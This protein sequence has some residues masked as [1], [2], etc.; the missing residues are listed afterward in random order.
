MRYFIVFALYNQTDSPVVHQEYIAINGF[1]GLD[2]LS[3]IMR[4][5]TTGS[6]VGISGLFELTAMEYYREMEKQL[7]PQ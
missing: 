5:Q 2:M 7:P 4:D 1:P 6:F 3:D